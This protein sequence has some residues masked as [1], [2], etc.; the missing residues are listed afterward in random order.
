MNVM[1]QSDTYHEQRQHLADL[2]DEALKDYFWELIGTIIEPIVQEAR[3]HTSPSIERSVL[4]R[5]GFSSTEA[6]AL[7]T[8]ITERGLLGHGAGNLVL[9]VAT[10]SGLDI[11]GA[12]R[13][14]IDGT[15]WDNVK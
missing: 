10:K 2:S 1:E 9:R 12:G 7:V 15:Q 5:M 13:A 8:M 14:L 3:T 4:L 6:K 11:R